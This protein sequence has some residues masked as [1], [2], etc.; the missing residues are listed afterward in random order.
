KDSEAFRSA[1]GGKT[2]ISDVTRAPLVAERAGN[3]ENG[4]PAMHVTTPI[5]NEDD[6]VVGVVMLQVDLLVL[7]KEINEVR[8]GDSG[9]AYVINQHGMMITESI[10][11]ERLR[12]TGLI[13]G[14]A[15]LELAVLEPQTTQLTKSAASCLKGAD[16][17]DVNGYINYAGE[18]V[19]GI[20]Y[21]IPELKWGVI[22]ERSFAE[23]SLALNT[24]KNPI[25]EILYYLTI[26]GVVLAVAGIAF[27]LIIG[28]KIANPLMELIAATRKMSA[29]DLSQ[30]VTI[31]TRDEVRELGDAFNVMAESVQ[32]K[33][34]NLQEAQNFAK[35]ILVSSTEH[36][37]I[38]GDLN[39]GILAFNEGARRMFG[40][41]PEELIQKS[42]I[43]L[44][45]TKEDVASGKVKQML[46]T[47]LSIG[48]YKDEMQ[49]IRKSGEIFTGYST[50]T[51]RQSADGTPIGFVMITRDITE[52]KSLEQEI[53]NYTVHLEKIVEERTQKL[54][55]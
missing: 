10:L 39:G 21:W 54:R 31:K 28:Q 26:T 34:A 14:S 44:L 5:K 43:Y 50:L 23:V 7:N 17:F 9:D 6:F 27:A 33:T 40:Y 8:Y 41:E 4:L 46:E 12:K 38:A 37:I 13:K 30:R 45:H 22:T 52:Q 53:Y 48:R 15:T 36:S 51:T 18:K 42:T 25:L 47:T 35:S 11:A 32:E 29:G 55:V 24:V 16:G 49:L 3:G 2:F 20:W 19:V 1:M